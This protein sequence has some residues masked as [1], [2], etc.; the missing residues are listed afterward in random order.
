MRN[1]T[2][3]NG[4]IPQIVAS[5]CDYNMH[6]IAFSMDGSG[7]FTASYYDYEVSTNEGW[8]ENQLVH[9]HNEDS[10]TTADKPNIQLTSIAMDHNGTLYGIA[11]DGNG[12]ASY[13]WR[14]DSSARYDLTW[15]ENITIT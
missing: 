5:S 11:S 10:G 6:S 12:I 8:F 2:V 15:K 3:I 1:Q 4:T 13:S 9:F 7:T 14:S